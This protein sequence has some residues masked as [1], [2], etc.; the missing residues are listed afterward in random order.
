[1]YSHKLRFI[2]HRRQVLS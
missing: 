1:M 2:Y